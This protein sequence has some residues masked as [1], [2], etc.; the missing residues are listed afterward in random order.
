[1]ENRPRDGGAGGRVKAIAA[2]RALGGQGFDARA[3]NSGRN[4]QAPPK[5]EARAVGHALDLLWLP[6]RA[7]AIEPPEC[8]L[9]MG[10][11]DSWRERRIGSQQSIHFADSRHDHVELLRDFPRRLRRLEP[12]LAR[13]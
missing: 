8:D 2:A 9:G 13:L 7:I 4:Q 11:E 6:E 10:L 12:D 3:R 5:C 1:G